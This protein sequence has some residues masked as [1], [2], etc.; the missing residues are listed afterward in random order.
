MS[1]GGE[2]GWSATDYLNFACQ[3][4]EDGYARGYGRHHHIGRLHPDLWCLLAMDLP[5]EHAYALVYHCY[6]GPLLVE[7]DS[8]VDPHV[9]V[10]ETLSR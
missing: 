1:E 4:V 8:S 3:A 2:E 5:Q 7:R 10:V 6:L 9:L